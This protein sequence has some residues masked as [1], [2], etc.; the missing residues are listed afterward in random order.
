[1]RH[2][3][4][5]EISK[6]DQKLYEEICTIAGLIPCD[7]GLGNDR[8]GN[9]IEL[10]CHIVVRAFAHVFE[11]VRCVDG[12]FSAGFPH[13]WLETDH[14][15]LIDVYPVAVIG[16]P[17]LYWHHPTCHVKP[18]DHLYQEESSVISGVYRSIG[19]WQFNRAVDIVTQFIMALH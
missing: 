8:N 2:P 11:K 3:V 15:S 13:S 1:M 9:R 12:Y 16:G 17:L 18:S 7:F 4:W 6:H 10:S 19:E 5:R 14:F